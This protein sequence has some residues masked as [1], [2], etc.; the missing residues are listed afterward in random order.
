[1]PR[2]AQEVF[3]LF[4]FGW[5]KKEDLPELSMDSTL[6][7]EVVN[8]F[9]T[10]GYDFVNPK[11]SPYYGIRRKKEFD[12]LE[13]LVRRT[14]RMDRRTFGA[15]LIFWALLMAPAII[16]RRG[17]PYDIPESDG[18][19][20]VDIHQVRL[21]YPSQFSSTAALI[22]QVKILKRLGFLETRNG[23][24][25]SGPAME[26][27]ID[28]EG[29]MDDIMRHR[30]AAQILRFKQ[31]LGVEKPADGWDLDDERAGGTVAQGDLPP[32]LLG[33]PGS[34]VPASGSSAEREG[35]D[36]R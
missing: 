17:L 24:L 11:G 20:Q 19:D 21:N 34:A 22:G 28:S 7:E 16:R 31:E 1:M 5:V 27:L 8:G 14:E 18:L 13:E 35:G 26:I 25:V 36:P 9:S 23:K 30:L 12:D 2:T 4:N 3:P 6:Y 29:L 15:L 10:L 33:A 32:N